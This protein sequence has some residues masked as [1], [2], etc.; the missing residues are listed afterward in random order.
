MAKIDNMDTEL[1]LFRPITKSKKGECLRAGATL[2]YS[3][4]RELFKKKM[5]DLEYHAENLGI[6]SLRAGGA[7]ATANTGVPDRLFKKHGRWHSEKPKMAILK[8]V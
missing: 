1:F 6:H 4:S 7:T 8:I 5:R 3:T 2:S